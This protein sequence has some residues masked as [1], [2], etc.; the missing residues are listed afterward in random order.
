MYGLSRTPYWGPGPQPRHVP[1]LGIELAILEYV[2]LEEERS[3]LKY[4]FNFN[5][6]INSI[7]YIPST[8]IHL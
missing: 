1:S 6:T 3:W 4:P 8:L 5:K 2:S 7:K